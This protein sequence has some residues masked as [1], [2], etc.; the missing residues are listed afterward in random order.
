MRVFIIGLPGVGKSTF[1]QTLAAYLNCDYVDLDS[2]IE[3]KTKTSINT[4]FEQYGE[5][6]FRKKESEC[7][8]EVIT[9]HPDMVLATGGGTPAHFDNMQTLLKNGTCILLKNDI[10]LIAKQ[11]MS[12]DQVRP[13]FLGL[14]ALEI[15]KRLSE[16]WT[17]RKPHYEQTHIITGVDAVQN[18]QLLTK[19]LELFTKKGNSLI[20]IIEID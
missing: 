8:L 2:W 20:G 5:E 1:A 15:E 17:K 7:L 16:I 9:Q 13:M 11:I 19:R 12:D 10:G 14:D 18:L 4:F 6:A 3:E